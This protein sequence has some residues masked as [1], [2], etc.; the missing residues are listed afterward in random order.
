MEQEV[1]QQGQCLLQTDKD[2]MKQTTDHCNQKTRKRTRTS[3]S[4]TNTT[5]GKEGRRSKKR[6]EEK[7]IVATV[8]AEKEEE[9]KKEKSKRRKRE[10]VE[11]SKKKKK[12]KTLYRRARTNSFPPL[13]GCAQY[14]GWQYWSAKSSVVAL[15][16]LKQLDKATQTQRERNWSDVEKKIDQLVRQ[17]RNDSKKRKVHSKIQIPVSCKKRRKTRIRKRR[18][19]RLGVLSKRRRSSTSMILPNWGGLR[20]RAILADE[21]AQMKK[22]YK[23]IQKQNM[24]KLKQ[25]LKV[26]FSLVK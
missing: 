25:S 20:L 12:Q 9:E 23:E 6:K 2:S 10:K 22:K 24:R 14:H 19:R 3:S 13:G 5:N 17:G 8:D 15:S 7:V 18:K 26:V 11:K 4:S 21:W 16:G 1:E